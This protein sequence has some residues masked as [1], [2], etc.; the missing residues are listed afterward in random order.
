MTYDLDASRGFH[1]SHRKVMMQ[2]RDFQSSRAGLAR[3]EEAIEQ[4]H[5]QDD[6]D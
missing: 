6:R 1:K 2:E 3:S 5:K 4:I